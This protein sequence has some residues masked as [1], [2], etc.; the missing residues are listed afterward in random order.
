MD[1]S[2]FLLFFPSRSPPRF[3]IGLA[4]PGG[5]D[6]SSALVDLPGEFRHLQIDLR[7][8]LD[9][10]FQAANEIYRKGRD[11]CA[12]EN[13]AVPN[14]SHFAIAKNLDL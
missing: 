6:G 12:G 8:G 10:V 2:S 13:F 5:F 1:K 14:S 7:V 3:K 9:E 11:L 4:G